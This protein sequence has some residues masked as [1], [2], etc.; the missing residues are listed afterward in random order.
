MGSEPFFLFQVHHRVII[1][2][3]SLHP[4]FSRSRIGDFSLIS[5]PLFILMSLRTA[6]AKQKK[7]ILRKA[8]TADDSMS[9]ECVKCAA[10]RLVLVR[11]PCGLAAHSASC[12][13]PHW[14]ASFSGDL[15]QLRNF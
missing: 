3:S 1:P 15:G 10:V 6:E 2:Q 12:L 9:K 14:Q 11:E 4:I 7:E 5:P 13:A 8:E